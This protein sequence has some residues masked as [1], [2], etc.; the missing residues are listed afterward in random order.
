MKYYLLADK[1]IEEILA[2]ADFNVRMR[3]LALEVR[4]HRNLRGPLGCE[5]LENTPIPDM[6]FGE[7]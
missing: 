2:K 6:R 5:W 1:E 4:E 7:G 3:S